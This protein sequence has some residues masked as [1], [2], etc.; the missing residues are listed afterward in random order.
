MSTVH[1]VIVTDRPERYAKQLAQHWAAKSTVTELEND[2]VQIEMGPGAVTVLRPKPGELH[3]E[4][5]S[6]EFGDVVKRHLER[7]GTRDE[8][9]LTWIG[10]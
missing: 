5:S 9:T 4:A 2:A 3:V 6:P 10:D 8:L 7:F 1:G